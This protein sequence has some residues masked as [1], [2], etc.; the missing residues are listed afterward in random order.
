ML[1]CFPRVEDLN[2]DA[3]LTVA[4]SLIVCAYFPT[5]L[6][7]LFCS[8]HVFMLCILV[9]AAVVTPKSI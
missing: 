9:L 7:M 6:L 1:L 5:V 8:I 2:C 4:H 3:R